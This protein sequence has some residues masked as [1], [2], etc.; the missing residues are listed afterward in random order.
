[1]LRMISQSG[2][3]LQVGG[4]AVGGVVGGAGHSEA[5]TTQCRAVSG[6]DGLVW[7]LGRLQSLVRLLSQFPDFIIREVEIKKRNYTL[8]VICTSPE[9]YPTPIPF[10][11]P[12]Q[13]LN[14]V[15]TLGSYSPIPLPHLGEPHELSCSYH[16]G[17]PCCHGKASWAG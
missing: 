11:Y 3:G 10:P 5:F 17:P 13:G 14:P 4:G 16:S 8:I 7:P 9:A 6:H 15:S 2:A 12:K 1:M